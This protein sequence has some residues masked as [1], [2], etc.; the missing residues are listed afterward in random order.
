MNRREFGK[1]STTA[2][3]AALLPA[4]Q[5]VNAGQQTE[6]DKMLRR[7]ASWPKKARRPSTSPASAPAR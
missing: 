5:S 4:S 3:L 1:L 7:S 6:L 2:A